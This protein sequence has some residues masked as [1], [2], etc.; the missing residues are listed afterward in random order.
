MAHIL[1]LDGK[2]AKSEIEDLLDKL[3]NSNLISFR[4]AGEK[5]RYVEQIQNNYNSDS[6]ISLMAIVT[7]GRHEMI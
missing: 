2:F 4:D 7:S 6:F 1:K 3:K 5:A